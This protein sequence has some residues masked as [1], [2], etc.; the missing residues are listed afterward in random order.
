MWRAEHLPFGGL[1]NDEPS[2]NDIVNNLR[3][4][5]QYFEAETELYQNFFRDYD[6]HSG[7]FAEPDPWG[8]FSGVNPYAYASA[9]PQGRV[10]PTGRAD[11]VYYRGGHSGSC[12]SNDGSETY[13]LGPEGVFSGHAPCTN[14]TGPANSLS[15]P[16]SWNNRYSASILGSPIPLGDYRMNLDDRPEHQDGRWW[17]LE[18]VRHVWGGWYRLGLNRGGFAWHLGR[19]S[20]GCVTTDLDALGVE[21]VRTYLKI[22]DLLLREAGS[23]VLHVKDWAWDR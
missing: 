8:L 3:F 12:T 20:A 7:R 13:Q 19:R 23:N 1:V 9:N 4:P 17:R 18:P 22:H 2:V 11:C 21:P 15:N 14:S 10:D 16:C 6:S 5:G